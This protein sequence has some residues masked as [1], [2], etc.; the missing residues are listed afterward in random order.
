M[1][2]PTLARAAGSA[3]ADAGTALVPVLVPPVTAAGSAGADA[4]GRGRRW[5]LPAGHGS[6]VDVDA[7]PD[8]HRCWC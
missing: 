6:E 2:V 8:L 3:G 1:P 4:A 5:G 7:A